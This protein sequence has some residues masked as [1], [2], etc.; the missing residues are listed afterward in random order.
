MGHGGARRP[1]TTLPI[2]ITLCMQMY[3]LVR[4]RSAGCIIKPAAAQ[5]A[6]FSPTT[7]RFISV[8]AVLCAQ[9]FCQHVAPGRSNPVSY[10]PI[11]ICFFSL[12]HASASLLIWK[13]ATGQ[14]TGV[15]YV[16]GGTFT[17]LCRCCF[18]SLTK[19]GKPTNTGGTLAYRRS[20]FS[21]TLPDPPVIPITVQPMPVCQ[22][23]A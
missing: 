14:H 1:P 16:R 7:N 13:E 6:L 11:T 9:K 3:S 4:I 23:K 21:M 15:A 17:P 22:I 19:Q 12:F 10:N 8:A 18:I 20:G 2:N 5:E